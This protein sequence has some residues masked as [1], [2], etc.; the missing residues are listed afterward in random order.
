MVLNFKCS[1]IIELDSLRLCIPFDT[2]EWKPLS[3]RGLDFP[4]TI[5]DGVPVKPK[6]KSTSQ[7]VFDLSP[8]S[9]QL[10][11]PVTLSEEKFVSAR[12]AQEVRCP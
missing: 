1:L 9:A 12:R 8:N 3:T 11:I 7:K 4:Y 2:L 10:Y 5:L 6:D